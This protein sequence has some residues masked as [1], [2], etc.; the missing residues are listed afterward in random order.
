MAA[1]FDTASRE[2]AGDSGARA[3]DVGAASCGAGTAATGGEAAFFFVPAIMSVA[4]KKEIGPPM[5]SSS[6]VT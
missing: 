6:P 5:A 1:A 2:V 4:E 3:G